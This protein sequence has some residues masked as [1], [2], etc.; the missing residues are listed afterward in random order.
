MPKRIQKHKIIEFTPNLIFIE[1]AFTDE[2]HFEHEG[3]DMFK[4]FKIINDKPL[5]SSYKFELFKFSLSDQ[6]YFIKKGEDIE[7]V[8]A[9]RQEDLRERNQRISKM[10]SNEGPKN[11]G[12]I[13]DKNL[14]DFDVLSIPDEFNIEISNCEFISSNFDFIGIIMT[15][16]DNSFYYFEYFS[17]PES[18]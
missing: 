8:F 16:T 13:F 1:G 17:D 10:F 4:F 12:E 14:T 11:F 7:K 9:E 15:G 2:P 6:Y 3:E 18:F 5:S